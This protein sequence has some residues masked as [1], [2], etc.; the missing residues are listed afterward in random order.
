MPK[1]SII[2][3]VYNVEK[4]IDR[5][6][7]SIQNQ[8]FHDY[9]VIVID[10][11][12]TDRSIEIA[13]KYPFQVIHQENQ[14]LSMA[15]NNGIKVAKGEYILFVDSD[16]FLDLELL[17]KLSESIQNNPDIVRFQI[18]EV[19]EEGRVLHSYPEK[20]FEGK[21]GV[22]AF[23]I[24]ATYH[25]V[26]NAWAYLFKRTYWEENHFA[27][28]KGKVHEDYGLI[29][30]AIVKAKKVNSISFIGYHYV[31]REGSLMANSDYQKVQ[32]K[33]E[34]FYQLYLLQMKRLEKETFDTEEIKSFLANSLL[35]KICELKGKDYKRYKKL[36]KSDR[37]VDNLL[38]DTLARKVKKMMFRISPKLTIQFL[39]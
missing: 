16:D 8:T 12:S 6:F 10:D 38:S 2:I 1:F 25:F 13:K 18:Q 39:R 34:D 19:D 31:Q 37:I 24:I 5:C 32:K 3:P 14:G 20:E 36:A 4:Y 29:P 23:S 15:R 17:Q 11:G 7:N 33:V 26:E 9:E 28:E 35:I 30:Y 21:T 22:D 27:F